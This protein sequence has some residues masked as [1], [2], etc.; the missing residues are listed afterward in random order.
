MKN[1]RKRALWFIAFA[2]VLLSATS[3]R[4]QDIS[5]DWQATLHVQRDLRCVL[6]IAKG[7]HGGW[8]GVFYSIDQTPVGTPVSTV[9]L[10]VLT[11][12]FSI[13]QMNAIFDGALSADGNT[14]T[15]T[16]NQNAGP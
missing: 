1:I 8:N 16:W 4:A 2:L 9:T 15:G 14:I 12:R 5:G 13:D 7:D 10:Q 6:H 3:L 11:F